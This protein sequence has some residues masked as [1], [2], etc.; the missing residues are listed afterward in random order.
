MLV[1]LLVLQQAAAA[2]P[3]PKPSP[4][5]VRFCKPHLYADHFDV[6]PRI[7]VAADLN[8]DGFADLACVYPP[9]GGILDVGLSEQGL[10]MHAPRDVQ[11]GLSGTAIAAAA[12]A[13]E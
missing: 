10:K 3:P 2:A 12:R 4:V 6:E 8:G 5:P 11:H 1:V 9:D 7:P 13:G